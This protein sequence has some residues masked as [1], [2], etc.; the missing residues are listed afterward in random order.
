MRIGVEGEGSGCVCVCVRVHPFPG[1]VLEE[2]LD[3]GVH[4][5]NVPRLVHKV[6]SSKASRKTVLEEHF[7]RSPLTC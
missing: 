6:D 5:V 1:L 3:D 2:G 4:G 7:T